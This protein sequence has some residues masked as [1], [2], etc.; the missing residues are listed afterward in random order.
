[1]SKRKLIIFTS[2]LVLAVFI[3]FSTNAFAGD[4]ARIGTAGGV[5]VQVPVGARD[6]AMGGANLS[7]TNGLEAIYWNPA[8]FASM[9]NSAAALF[10]TMTIFN[11]VHVNYAAVGVQAGRLGSIGF[12]IK[13]FDFGDI[14]VTTNQDMDGSAGA[15]FSP[16]YV[17]TG[18]TYARRLTDAI[19]VG[20][21][22]K[23]I[24]ESVPRA[25]ASA[26]AFDMG[27]QYHNLGG[28]NGLSLGLA[29]RNIG[30]NLQYKGSAFLV[31][32]Q[33]LG[34]TRKDFRDRP[35]ESSQLPAS[36]E[37]GL[38]YTYQFAEDNSL[39]LTGLF[40]N[41]NFENDNYKVGAEYS[42][43][44]LIALRGGYRSVVNTESA[45]INY[46]FTLG[47]GLHYNLGGTDLTFDYAYRD[48]Q[49][50]DGNSLFSLKIGF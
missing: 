32:A 37:L 20:I 12:T 26:L 10:S 17:T 31:Q 1:M 13:A 8:G 33:D 4:P 27:I 50:F 36:I 28:L 21:T 5:Q 41:N 40:Q 14:P 24:Y 44:D 3:G 11:D 18:A 15:L 25:S 6:L 9:Q 34:S 23:M 48:S 45:E 35:T 29:V 38:G 42:F 30:T 22:G 16:T 2:L 7:N 49:Y 47:V 46:R 43:K 39:L 19:Q